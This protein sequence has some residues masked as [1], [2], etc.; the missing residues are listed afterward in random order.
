MISLNL[1]L[2]FYLYFL[3]FLIPMF[4]LIGFR[5]VNGVNNNEYIKIICTWLIVLMELNFV[6]MILTIRNY[7][8]NSVK[9]GKQG[10]KGEIGSRGFRGRSNICNQCGDKKLEKYGSNINDLNMKISDP[11]L[12]IGKCVFPFVFDNEFHYDCVKTSRT[13]NLNNDASVNGW[14]ATE[15]NSDLTYKTFAYCKN[16]SKNENKI[17]E[18]IKRKQRENSYN[19]T[20]TGILDIKIVSGVRTTISCPKGY[21]KLDI[22][23]N[24][25]ADGNFVYLCK[26]EGTDD[27]GVQDIRI[28]SGTESCPGGF[29][30]LQTNLNDGYPDLSDSDKVDICVK[31]GGS[32]F[33]KDITVTKEKE[34]PKEYKTHPMN[35]N[36]NIGGEDIFFCT[37]KTIK[38]GITID[39]AFVWNKDNNIYFFKKD[40]YWMYDTLKKK[41]Q[42]KQKTST[43]WGKIPPN[44]DAVFTDPNDNETYFFK[45]SKFY[46]YD[47]E[48]EKV[49]KG[50]PKYIRDVW[51]NV[52]DNLDAVYVG[53]NK[54][55]YFMYKKRYYEWNNQ[56]KRAE[57]AMYTDRK[58]L[59]APSNIS[60]MFY[61]P[62]KKMTYIIKSNLLYK[63]NN[64]RKDSATPKKINKEFMF[65]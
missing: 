64:F 11:K 29:R 60:A 39:S 59:G 7:M 63:Y 17:N 38:Q 46:K 14:C 57:S 22:D 62:G 21:N 51:K 6:S 2:K 26:K 16:S 12:K 56:K 50:Y 18:N 45:G 32:E 3:Y 43:F 35:L 61:H 5:L 42:K 41:M 9:L 24:L 44:I 40:Y 65:N 54:N 10:K 37:S 8:K 27:I 55:V 52:P 34:C 20:N 13:E 15:L 1:P 49:A 30:K 4:A 58:W 25:K 23:L 31:K 36:K 28:K 33:I 48:N 19:K 53:P 47:S